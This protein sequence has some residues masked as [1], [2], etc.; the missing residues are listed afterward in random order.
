MSKRILFVDDEPM[1]LEAIQHSLRSMR[2]EWEVKFATSGAEALETMSQTAFDVVITDMRMPGMDGAQLLELVKTRSP[3]TVRFILSGQSDRETIFR[4]VGPS[5]QYLAK[6]CDIDE[7]KARLT[8]AFALRDMLDNPNLKEILSRLKSVPS[9]PALYSAVSEALRSP[10][11]SLTQ[12][13]DLIA[14]DMGMCAKV[15]QLVNSAFFG[16]ACHVSSPH[17][18]IA[19]IGFENLKALVLSMEVFS[20]FGGESAPAFSFLWKH[21]IATASFA[22]AIATVQRAP[23]GTVDDAFTAGLLHDVGQLVLASAFED[24]Y[25]KVL[26]RAEEAG[27]GL[28]ACEVEAFGCAHNAAG[29]YLLGLWGLADSVVEAVAWHHQPA[30]AEP[31]S[32]SVLIAV[33]VADC[34]ENGRHPDHDFGETPAID[35]PLLTR[36]GLQMQLPL[37][38]KACQEVISRSE[39]HA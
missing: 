34:Y 8:R 16:L 38:S 27:T 2:A 36:L 20:A 29:A 9:L 24:K 28:A 18:A 25:Q 30:N 23:R 13:G 12:I 35:E 6:P 15:L 22:K 5:H 7:L 3:R 39:T 19:M 4:S 1:I 21:S 17:Q 11:T 37:W 14:Q 26:R 32:F 33:H 31:T 10:E